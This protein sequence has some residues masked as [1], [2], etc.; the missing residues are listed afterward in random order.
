M[1]CGVTISEQC[2]DLDLHPHLSNTAQTQLDALHFFLQQNVP[3]LSTNRD[4]RALITTGKKPTTKD[5]YLLLSDTGVLWLPYKWI[6]IKAI[7]PR[8][9]FF[10]WLSF[11]GRLNTKDNMVKKHWHHDAGCDLC[12]ATES[13][14]HIALRCRYS[15]WVWDKWQVNDMALQATSI[16]NF[17]ENV[18]NVQNATP[19]NN[20]EIWA[21]CF[22]A[23]VLNIWKHRNNRVFNNRQTMR[24]SLLWQVSEDIK[25]WSHRVPKM[26]PRLLIWAQKLVD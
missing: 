4:S 16:T 24:Q 7:P 12:P 8:H 2:L 6:W 18:P 21:T 26:R 3:H 23:A 17:F 11:H 25:L 19:D 10:L 15:H 14:H 1:R 13:I 9:K 20:A 22:A 5:I